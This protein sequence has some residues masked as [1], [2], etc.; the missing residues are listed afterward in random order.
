MKDNVKFIF[1]TGGVISGIG[2]G[3]SFASIGRI[4]KDRGY[5]IFAMKLDPYLNYDPGTM[6]PYQHGE[7]YVTKDGAET[8]LD[9]GHYERII[10]E[11]LTQASSVTSGRVYK[12]ILSQERKG[13]YNGT[14]VQVIPHVTNE[15]KNYIKRAANESE[16]DI[17][18]VEVGGTVGD[19]ESEPF[20]EAIREM[21]MDYGYNSTFYI[22]LTLVPYVESTLEYKTKPTQHSVKLLRSLG[23][24]PDLIILRSRGVLSS[25]IKAKVALFCDVKEEAVINAPNLKNILELPLSFEKQ[26]VDDII[27]DH[28]G[29]PKGSTDMK[30]WH[31]LVENINK[32]KETVKIAIIGKYVK[33][34]DAYLSVIQALN[35]AGYYY[36]YNVEIIWIESESI[37]TDNIKEILKDAKGI[38]IPGGFGTRGIEGMVLASTYARENSIPLL[39]ICLGMQIEAIE[40]ARNVLNLKDANSIE[41]N[42]E[43]KDPIINF[44]NGQYDGIDLGGT[45]RLG[46]Y[47]CLIDQNSKVASLYNETTIEERHRHRYEFN[48]DYKESFNKAGF[49]IVGVNPDK[50]LVEIVE[51]KD[52]PFYIGCQFHPEFRSRPTKP[53]PLF[54]G[55][56]K[57]SIENKS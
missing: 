3:I 14:T 24:T 5:K 41:F 47:T 45:L 8:D 54:L 21:R 22:H 1:V 4:L 27:I 53:H 43:V 46:N 33:L 55:L 42:P 44:L 17:V 30:E 37:T 35:H 16:A 52:H 12:R 48:N 39:G 10:D 29:F 31:D 11:E 25:D 38:I 57:A 19:I 36:H 15:I 7:V 13:F 49:K 28:F 9:L 32:S 34:H 23:I 40:F 51:L 18:M 20:L 26:N 50:D 56:I 6:S 2:K